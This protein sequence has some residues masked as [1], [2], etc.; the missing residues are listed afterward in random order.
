MTKANL[1][2]GLVVVGAALSVCGSPSVMS[3]SPRL[4]LSQT[5]ID[6]G[7]IAVL[8]TKRASLIVENQ[9]RAPL[10]LGQIALAKDN[11]PF[12]IVDAP[13]LIAPGGAAELHLVF[14]PNAEADFSNLLIIE[15]D[16][17]AQPHVEIE[18]K[19]AGSTR[20]IAT[21]APLQVDFGTVAECGAANQTISITSSGNAD[22]II[23]E[24]AL[25]SDSSPAFRVVGSIKTPAVVRSNASPLVLTLQVAPS[26]GTQGSLSGTIRFTTTDPDQRFVV[27]PLSAMV[28][29]APIASIAASD[30]AAPG[31]TIA[32]DGSASADLDGS[33]A[34]T[35]SW[36]LRRK[37]T[38]AQ[39]SVADAKAAVASLAT[40][41]W[42]L[43]VY[44]VELSVTDSM[45]AK[46]CEPAR[47]TVTSAPPQK[48]LVEMFWDNA[49]TDVDLHVLQSPQTA[50]FEF[51]GDCHYQNQRPDWGVPG[52]D[53]D[54]NL[55]RDARTGYGPEVFGYMNPVASTY[56]VA[57]VFANELLNPFPASKAT[58]RVYWQGA[59]KF[60][61]SRSLQQAGDVWNA[62][63]VEWPSGNVVALP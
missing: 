18:L 49:K 48:L 38:T 20:A 57:V 8:N 40:D 53:D 21:F 28:N 25:A 11:S 14:R 60:E 59:L 15:S 19:G 45:G 62:V 13:K 34:L 2:C 23:E 51:P 5:E 42:A 27:I 35:Y 37:P 56:R 36:T 17:A 22:L 52:P 41:P 9:G 10:S 39:A 3:V 16:D 32:L 50:L 44:E 12:Q 29:R 58:V 55:I 33:D 54:P 61:A 30:T 6:F 63:D 7:K 47:A 43:G 1:V 4:Q 24:I 46:S 31:Q 26:I